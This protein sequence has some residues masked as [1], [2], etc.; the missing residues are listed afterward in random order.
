M[1][2]VSLRCHH[3]FRPGPPDLALV[4]AG[5]GGTAAGS[6]DS[7][8]ERCAAGAG[9]DEW[10]AKSGRQRGRGREV[11]NHLGSLELDLELGKS[12]KID[13]EGKTESLNIRF[14][15]GNGGSKFESKKENG[16][17]QGD[18]S[19]QTTKMVELAVFHAISSRHLQKWVSENS[20]DAFVMGKV[21]KNGFS[22]HGLKPTKNG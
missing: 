14:G 11:G 5:R 7:A 9:A 17:L 10:G 20:R 6:P 21:T 1:F 19:N 15:S 16:A 18:Y 12:E 3:R 13:Y 22:V 8:A 2:L 4:A